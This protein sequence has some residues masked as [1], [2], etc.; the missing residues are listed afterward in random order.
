ME[1][2]DENFS[3]FIKI[4]QLQSKVFTNLLDKKKRFC[5]IRLINYEKQI[6]IDSLKMIRKKNTYL[7]Q[8]SIY[9]INKLCT[10]KKHVKKDKNNQ[11]Y[12][13]I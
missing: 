11:T 12:S 7:Y 5:V 2:S 6:L 1:K 8:S 4:C 3:L 9:Y 10:K 13:H